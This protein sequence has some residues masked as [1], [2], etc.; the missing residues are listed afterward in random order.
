MAMV[1]AQKAIPAGSLAGNKHSPEVQMIVS[2]RGWQFIDWREIWRYRDLFYFLVLRGVKVRYAQSVLGVGWAVVQPL[3]TM[4]IFTVVFGTVAK[5]S[6]DGAPYAVFSYVALVPWTYFSNALTDASS[7][8]VKNSNIISKVYFPR[9]I[10]PLSSVAGKLIDFAIAMTLVAGLMVWYRITPT[11]WVAITPLLVLLVVLTAAGLGSL[12]AALAVQYRD[13]NYGIGFV[14]QM[15]MF[16]SPVVY[17]VSLLPERLR[18][19]YALN[20]ISGVIE[21]FRAAYL[22]TQP[23]PWDMLAVGAASALTMAVIGVMYFR[24]MERNFSDVA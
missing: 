1:R 21:G 4:V 24:R 13:V 14:V 2:S 11:P 5:V 15:L 9:L 22:G 23:M 6:S 7:S 18:L 16:A 20:P 8:L 3:F 10:M 19:V 17:P 12:L